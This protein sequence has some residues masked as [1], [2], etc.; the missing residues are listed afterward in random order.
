MIQLIYEKNL[1]SGEIKRAARWV[2][3]VDNN[4]ETDKIF[5]LEKGMEGARRDAFTLAR[6]YISEA[7]HV[8]EVFEVPG[9]R[10]QIWTSQSPKPQVADTKV[11]KEA[12]S[13]KPFMIPPTTTE[14]QTAFA[15]RSS[16][17]GPSDADLFAGQPMEPKEIKKRLSSGRK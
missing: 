16:A 10:G 2:V 14:G 5:Q 1:T 6:G 17:D 7:L 3:R 8:T 13:I 15:N 12:P 4:P 11:E 9:T